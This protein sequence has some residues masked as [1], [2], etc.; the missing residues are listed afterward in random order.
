[1]SSRVVRS[2]QCPQELGLAQHRRVSE[3]PRACV[4]GRTHTPGAS[5]TKAIRGQANITAL[6]FYPHN[7]PCPPVVSQRHP[8][9]L[10]AGAEAWSGGSL[11]SISRSCSNPQVVAVK[12]GGASCTYPICESSAGKRVEPPSSGESVSLCPGEVQCEWLG[13]RVQDAETTDPFTLLNRKPAS[14][15]ASKQKGVL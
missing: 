10:S 15:G 1:M 3:G 4:S 13:E 14:S 11:G 9:H 2:L 6:G 8:D 7:P 5:V 12:E